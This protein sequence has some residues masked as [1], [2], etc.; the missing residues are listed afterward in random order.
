MEKIFEK[1]LLYDFYGELLTKHQQQIYEDAVFNDMSL[2]EIAEEAGIS[3]QGVHDLI[4]RC[5]KALDEYEEKLHLVERFM[6]AKQ[7]VSDIIKITEAEPEVSGD[8]VQEK[9]AEIKALSV[10]LLNEL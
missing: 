5:D 6:K 4:K 10:S 9:L 7:V 1:G 2:G 3:R 8:R